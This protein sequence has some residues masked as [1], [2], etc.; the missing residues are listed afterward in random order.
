MEND[1]LAWFEANKQDATNDWHKL[2]GV[3]CELAKGE[4]LWF[5]HNPGIDSS[6]WVSDQSND[7]E[8]LLRDG[9]FWQAETL[10]VEHESL[11]LVIA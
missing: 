11:K 10:W 8:R 5:S 4:K 9:T 6:W 2:A 7:G 3:T 1:F